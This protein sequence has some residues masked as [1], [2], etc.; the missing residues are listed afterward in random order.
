MDIIEC[1]RCGEDYPDG[2]AE[3][4]FCAAERKHDGRHAEDEWN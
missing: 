3:C 4:P 2:W 1:K